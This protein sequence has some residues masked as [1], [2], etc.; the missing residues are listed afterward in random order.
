MAED[1]PQLGHLE[2]VDLRGIWKNESGDF[3]PWLA[4]EEN[5][6]LLSDTI[7]IDLELHAQEKAVGPYSAD[8][9]C[10][11]TATGAWVLIENQLERTDHTHLGQLITYSAGL[12]AVTI[13]W[14]A[15]AITDEHRAALDWLNSITDDGFNF[16]GI[17]IELWKIG[18]SPI[19][20][21]FNI[22]SQPNDWSKTLKQS[23]NMGTGELSETKKMQFEY[24]TQFNQ[25]MTDS[26]SKVKCQKPMP[27][28]WMNH[29]IGRSGFHMSSI[30]SGYDSETNKYGGEI[31]VELVVIDAQKYYGYIEA[32]KDVFEKELGFPLVWSTQEGT[33]S[34]KI[35]AKKNVNT[36]DIKDWINQHK[37]L[38]DHLETFY[39]VFAPKIKALPK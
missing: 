28:H 38:K 8:I 12:D 31:R 19:A 7:G 37:W 5:L 26:K 34:R 29:S 11:D 22:V 16:F 32:Q 30:F 25:Y 17:E 27:Q 18:D 3:T 1:K 23:R 2:K 21:K 35:Y 14:I 33:K 39:K 24:W 15:A 4:K 6:K 20:P 36:S 10:K 13:A 9:L